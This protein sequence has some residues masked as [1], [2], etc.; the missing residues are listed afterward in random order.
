M[1]SD[2]DILI[3]ED[4]LE[5]RNWLSVKLKSIN[6]IGKKDWS[7]SIAKAEELIK[8]NNYKLV[9]LD[10]SLPDGN[11][12]ALLKKLKRNNAEQHVYIFSIYNALRNTCLR[13]GADAFYDKN[14]QQDQLIHA[15]RNRL[16]I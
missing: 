5:I 1:T 16:S 15:I 11:G 12:L 8:R 7:T 9:V 14:T 2:I 6:W 10:L 13:H 4:E 3:V